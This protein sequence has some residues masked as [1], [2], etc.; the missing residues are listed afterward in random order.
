MA[1]SAEDKNFLVSLY[2]GYFNR[3]PD[4]AGLQFWID[5][6]EAGRDTNTIAA[7]FAASPEAKSLYPFLTTPDVSSPTSFITAVY[8]N[9]FNRAPDAAGQAFWEAQLSSG[10]V[11]PADAIDAIIKGATT[12][13][14]STILANKNAVGLDFATDAGNTPGFTFDLNGSSGSAARSAISGVTEDASTVVAA[15]AATD[16]YLNGV[17]GAGETFT[18]T[19]GVDNVVGGTGDDVILG[20]SNDRTN[21]FASTQETFGGLDNVDGGDGVDTL[22]L[23]NPNGTLNLDASVSVSNV[24]ELELTNAQGSVVANVGSWAG[25]E[26]VNVDQ[27]DAAAIDVD[28]NANATSVVTNGGAAVAI[29]DNGSATTTAD[30][31]ASVSITGNTGAATIGSDALTSLSLKDS[32]GGAT[33]TAAAGTRE[34][35][36]NL[37][38]V[39]GTITDATA[40]SL[41]VNASGAESTGV[42]IAAAAAETVAIE[43]AVDL[44][45]SLTGAAIETIDVNGEGEVVL[46][47]VQN[48]A[49]L[50]AIDASDNTGGVTASVGDAV[51]FTGGAGD[52]TL[53]VGATTEANTLG[54]GDDTFNASALAAAGGSVDGGDGIDTVA[55]SSANAA[56][57]SA[58]TDFEADISNFEK[59]SVG[60]TAGNATDVVNLD[61]LDD[62]DYVVS[63]GTAAGTTAGGTPEVATVNFTSLLE[64]QSVTVGGQTY[65]NATG[66]DM[67]AAQVA[68]AFAAA[69]DISDGS[70]NYIEAVNGAE[71]TYTSSVNGDVTDVTASVSN[72]T[73]ATLAAATT[74]DGS[75]AVAGATETATV[76]FA[77]IALGQSITIDGITVTATGGAATA[78]DIATAFVSGSDSGNAIVSGV[79]GAAWSEA[80]GGSLNEVVFTSTT[81]NTDVIDLSITGSA[82][83]PT[84]VKNDGNAPVPGATEQADVVFTALNSGESVE[85]AGRIVTAN[86][87]DLTANEVEAAYLGGVNAGNAVISGTLAGWAVAENG[88]GAGDATLTFTSNTPNA[89]VADIDSSSYGV[90]GAAAPVAPAVSVV[91]GTATGPGGS[92]SVTGMA[93]DGTLELTGDNN[94]TTTVIMKDATGSADSLNLKLNGSANLAA[95]AVIVAGVETINIEATDSSADTVTVANP[96]ADSD[97]QLN[98]ADAETITVSGNHGVNFT[99]SNVANVTT[100]DA[101][102]VEANVNTTGLTA[103]QVVAANGVAGA[104]TFT[105]AVTDEDVTITTGNG[106]DMI[107][108][109]SVGTTGTTAAAATITTGAGADVVVGGADADVIN[110]GSEND[111]VISSTGADNITLGEGN[112][113]YVLA[114]AGDSTIAVRDMITDFSA[115]TATGTD[116]VNGDLIDLQAFGAGA[117]D[118]A[119]FANAADASTFLGNNDADGEMNIAFDSA[120]GYLYIDTDDDGIANSVIE[121]TGVTTIDEAAFLI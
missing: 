2:V 104:V 9:L 62:I 48:G 8:A 49:A 1:I 75:P 113:T 36:V 54:A 47:N 33:V 39:S 96:T 118:V 101:S 90:Q 31:L 57:L 85:V 44:S 115:N 35:E 14:D 17:A 100:L 23:S 18:L 59:V 27:R 61:N 76:T 98:A 77:D 106:N 99:G 4:P 119:V 38:G 53:T 42:A 87:G 20:V 112:D 66:A 43:A 93:N 40:T 58:G 107:N 117:L 64:G 95:G 6:V 79:D 11:S 63:A 12:A 55:L 45:T 78:V 80:A 10:A 50:E 60:E 46:T 73:P 16:A 88:G 5:Q 110:T 15:Q 19:T 114:N 86:G 7:D 56:T 37:D 81:P 67:T 108:A 82:A 32:S 25:L 105:A 92:L 91:D 26:T 94:G 24:E 89:D 74:T 97:L 71:V 52:D 111:T 29:D 109:S 21:I 41:N 103:A 30:T 3:A 70:G 102:G 121:L 84:V 69:N 83:T 22:K 72:S 13:P 34:L 116:P 65:T 28:T 120:T 68:S 51:M